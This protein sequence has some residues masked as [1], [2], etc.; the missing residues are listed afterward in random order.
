MSFY[1]RAEIEQYRQDLPGYGP[2]DNGNGCFHIREMGLRVIASNGM[3]W[4]HVSVS[5]KTMVPNYEEMVWCK[6]MFWHAE[7]C[8]M[9]LFV[10]ASEHIDCHSYC[11]H[12][13]RP[14]DVEIP[15]PPPIL[16]GCK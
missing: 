3:G 4:E 16:V 11:L 13:W 7:D 5:K 2:G 8:A 10:P 1:A 6:N 9:Q 14:I 12:I 15:V